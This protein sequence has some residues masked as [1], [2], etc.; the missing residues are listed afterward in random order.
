MMQDAVYSP[1]KDLVVATVQEAKE[2][3]KSLVADSEGDFTLD[4]EGVEMID[5]KG[6]GLVIA[7]CNSLASAGRKLR[8]VRAS[9][10]IA[11]LFRTMRLDRHFSVE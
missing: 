5:S 8:V 2:R 4:F 3:I 11:E 6:L 1:R 10:E 9:P 7:T